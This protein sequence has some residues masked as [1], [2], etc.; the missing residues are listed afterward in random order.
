MTDQQQPKIAPEVLTA[1]VWDAI[2]DIPGVV[3]LHRN[4]LQQ[5]GERVKLDWR[6]PVRLSEEDGE[7]TFEVH[8]VA[9]AGQPLPPIAEAARSALRDYA[10]RAL[11]M[12]TVHVRVCIDDIAEEPPP[13]GD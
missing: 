1:A 13:A 10:R 2:K 7:T 4:P 11:A 12:P 6:G 5:L 9:V 8:V 3:D